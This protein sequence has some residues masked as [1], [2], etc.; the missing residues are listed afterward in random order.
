MGAFESIERTI[1]SGTKWKT[2][3]I[4]W[5]EGKYFTNQPLKIPIWL[6]FLYLPQSRDLK[7]NIVKPA[8]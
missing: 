4:I 7:I 5:R 8:L 6:K 2:K 3:V 1:A